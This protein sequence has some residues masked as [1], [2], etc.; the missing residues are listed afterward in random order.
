MNRPAFEQRL[1]EVETGLPKA[2]PSVDVAAI[3]ADATSKLA[4]LEQQRLRLAPRTPD[5]QSEI[6]AELDDVESEIRSCRRTL[7]LVALART[8]RPEEKAAA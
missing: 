3:A 1:A 8:A 7:E 6:R 4:E 5:R 2:R